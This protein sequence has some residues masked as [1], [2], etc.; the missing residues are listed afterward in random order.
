MAATDTMIVLLQ[1]EIHLW[2][3]KE[4]EYLESFS[5]MRVRS[6]WRT[7]GSA[8]A[9]AGSSSA[10]SMT[11]PRAPRRGPRLQVGSQPA[12]DSGAGCQPVY[13]I[14]ASHVT[15]HMSQYIQNDFGKVQINAKERCKLE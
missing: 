5:A 12:G 8:S 7:A 15:C 1:F 2:S 14:M 10:P 3:D 11:P 9:T 13:Q 4:L 6:T